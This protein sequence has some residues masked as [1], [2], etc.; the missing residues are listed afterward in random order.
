[1]ALRS[2]LAKDWTIEVNTG[3]VATPT[4]TPV[5]GLTQIREAYASNMEDDSDFDSGGWSSSQVT[6]RTWRLECEGRR[7][8]TEATAFTPDPGQEFVRLR[9]NDVGIGSNVQCRYY[10]K[11]GAPDAYTGFASV[12]YGGGGGGVT[13][14]E[15]FSVTFHGQGARTAIT[16]PTA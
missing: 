10:R 11:D 3:S 8:R 9:G 5:R 14:L 12:E 7:K 4:W 1:M 6:Q 16:N 2:L 15:P 13:D